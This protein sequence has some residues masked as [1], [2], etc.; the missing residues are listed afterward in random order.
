MVY[1]AIRDDDLNFFS[2]VDDLNMVYGEISSFPISY[3][4]IPTVTDV[5]TLGKCPDT[6]GN[7]TP[8]WIGNNKDLVEWLKNGL[9]SQKIDVCMHGI[10][11]GYKFVNGERYAEMEWRKEDNLVEKITEYKSRLEQLLDY[12]LKVFVAPSNKISHYGIN[13]VEQAGLQFSG[14]VPKNFQRDYTVKNVRSYFKQWTCRVLNGLDYPGVL[15][16]SNHKEIN[17]CPIKSFDYLVKMFNYSEKHNLPM[18]VNVHYW[19]LR[20][21]KNYHD[22]LTKFVRYALDKGAVPVRLSDILV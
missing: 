12:K 8:R 3:A 17:A 5:S 15:N 9:S 18:V 13:C 14:L 10:T 21:Y 11:H 2:K 4:I 1:L 19:H 7:E 22:I 20:D 16:Y 6:K